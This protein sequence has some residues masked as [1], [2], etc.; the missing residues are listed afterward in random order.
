MKKRNADAATNDLS[1]KKCKSE[2]QHLHEFGYQVA[3]ILQPGQ[4]EELVE[5]FDA[6]LASIGTGMKTNDVRTM[7]VR[8]RPGIAS[9][10]ILKDPKCGFAHSRS[11]WIARDAS[12][13][14]FRDLL[15]EN[16]IVSSLDT[17]GLWPNWN[18]FKS[19]KDKKRNKTKSSWWHVDQCLTNTDVCY[20]GMLL[21]TDAT[22]NTGGF[23]V[24]PGS[25]KRHADVLKAFGKDDSKS[26]FITLGTPEEANVKLS[27]IGAEPIGGGLLV[28]AKAGSL[29]LWNSKTMHTSIPG[30]NPGNEPV[31]R[32]VC[33]VSM[34]PR[35]HL[36]KKDDEFRRKAIVDEISTNHWCV[37]PKMKRETLA[38]P[39]HKSFPALKS[40]AMPM[41]EVFQK[42]S[43]LI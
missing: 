7:D 23:A 10:G 3:P 29:I 1:E 34:V 4:V 2:F 8:A 25:H 9:V 13:N 37:R 15:G 12:A 35:S 32:R 26:N 39:R 40:A 30:V 22:I 21:L 16:E 11:M 14:T 33:Y 43:E 18:L 20:Q 41:E 31:I 28:E 19:A 27:G 42:Y 17:G 24:V 36:T 38:Y 5:I 6:D